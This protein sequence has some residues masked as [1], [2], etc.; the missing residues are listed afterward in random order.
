MNDKIATAFLMA[1]A[2]ALVAG[3]LYIFLAPIPEEI[4]ARN[5]KEAERVRATVECINQSGG[6]N[7]RDY[8][9]AGYKVAKCAEQSAA[10]G[11]EAR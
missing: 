8:R 11:S 10:E 4:G 2:G 1:L 6:A 7:D 9:L 3:I 5:P